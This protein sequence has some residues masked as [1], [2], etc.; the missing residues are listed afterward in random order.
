MISADGTQV[1]FDYLEP[2]ADRDHVV[3]GLA[4]VATAGGTVTTLTANTDS[5]IPDLTNTVTAVED[6][7]AA[8]SPDGATV[9]FAR[10]TFT[11]TYDST[12]TVTAQTQ[13]SSVGA[14]AA[15]GAS[16]AP[17]V[18]VTDADGPTVDLAGNIDYTPE[19]FADQASLANPPQPVD[20]DALVQQLTPGTG[21]AAPTTSTLLTY[22]QARSVLPGA[23]AS[24]TDDQ[25]IVPPTLRASRCGSLAA[26]TF[27]Y[28][29]PSASSA[30]TVTSYTVGGVLT[31]G[32]L[33]L[34]PA[35]YGS[36]ESAA[37]GDF[38]VPIDGQADLDAT[39][40]ELVYARVTLTGNVNDPTSGT[41]S[42]ATTR[43][44]DVLSGTHQATLFSPVVNGTSTYLP[45]MSE[46]QG[47]AY[48]PL[49]AP[50]RVL[51]TR[52]G[53]GGPEAPVGAGGRRDVLMTGGSSPIL[54]QQPLSCATSPA[55]R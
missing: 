29:V 11:T 14:V 55:S 10:Y 23:L 49:A 4:V 47:S 15:N 48:V 6:D 31:P 34:V 25:Y 45:P 53:I 12:G 37:C 39:G 8:F 54:R 13:S 40:T 1:A 33:R 16:A 35:T 52:K 5:D 46:P 26:A 7:S 32:T 17:T 51:D 30:T 43:T 19:V 2:G 42:A 3:Q 18:L 50:Y 41:L 44:V 21:G 28:A 24:A 27:F 22:G 9:P 20:T 36:G 38:A